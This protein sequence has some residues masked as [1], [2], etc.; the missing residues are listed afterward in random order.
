MPLKIGGS[1]KGGQ[2][3]A[4]QQTLSQQAAPANP[5]TGGQVQFPQ[6]KTASHLITGSQQRS[7]VEQVKAQQQLRSKMNGAPDF[8]LS[9]GELADLYFLD[10][11][12]VGPNE[13]DTPMVNIHKLTIGGRPQAFVC[14]NATEGECIACKS[15]AER[16]QVQTVQLFTVINTKPY[17]IK[18]GPEKG[19]TLAA[20]L[21]IF[22]ATMKVRDILVKKAEHR[23]NSLAGKLWRF[24]RHTKQD[25]ATGNDIEFLQE[26]P[27]KDVLAKYPMLGQN[28]EGKWGHGPT[29][30]IDY[31]SAY[32][33]ITNAE[34]AALR[35]DI[36]SAAGW[37]G[38]S[39]GAQ[40]TYQPQ[41]NSLG[42]AD[43]DDKIPF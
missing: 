15:N 8:W 32:G 3:A 5:A 34:L 38:A 12:L 17:T 43:L 40:A 16:S 35:P 26:F 7:Q 39:Y 27:M 1:A 20:R 19:K 36:A 22:P 2:P 29:K 10:G 9:H 25:A 33:I 21:Q 42:Q 13:W 37:S 24:T 6:Q 28:A 23:N 11:T 18:H 4:Q 30:P 14:M 41:T 31:A